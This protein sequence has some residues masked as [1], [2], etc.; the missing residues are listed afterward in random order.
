[1]GTRL[2]RANGIQLPMTYMEVLNLQTPR[3][4]HLLPPQP[5]DCAAIRSFQNKQRLTH[6][7]AL[8]IKFAC[9]TFLKLIR[10]IVVL[11]GLGEGETCSVG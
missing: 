3:D 9:I 5:E 2:Q 1:M 4:K 7:G 6:Y 11:G 8:L 10:S